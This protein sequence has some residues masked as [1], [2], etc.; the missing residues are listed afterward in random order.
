M[1][2]SSISGIVNDQPSSVSLYEI[3]HLLTPRKFA[4][5]C[6]NQP[7]CPPAWPENIT[8]KASAASSEA[9]SSMYRPAVQPP[10]PSGPGTSKSIA[11]FNPLK[12]IIPLTS[13]FMGLNP[14]HFSSA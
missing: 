6:L 2:P 11:T 7:V 12:S 1:R 5:I 10:E 14:D 3:E 8:A 13:L 9:F 4:I